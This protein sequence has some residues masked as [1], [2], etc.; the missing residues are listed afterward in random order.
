MSAKILNFYFSLT[1]FACNSQFDVNLPCCNSITVH[2]IVTRDDVIKWRLFHV[3]GPLCGEFTGHRWIPLT[4]ASDA[5]LWCFLW[6][7]PWIN[8]WVNN[9]EDGD[10]RRHRAHH[11]V[12]IIKLATYATAAELSC[13]VE[14]FVPITRLESKWQ[15][16]LHRIRIAIEKLLVKCAPGQ[17]NN[18]WPKK[19]TLIYQ[20]TRKVSGVNRNKLNCIAGIL[21]K[22]INDAVFLNSGSYWYFVK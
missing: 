1:I 20:D 2:Q 10:L 18:Y 5:E 3:T 21:D 16:H 13:H 12:I 6:S 9:C 22:L 4:K 15:S 14:N 8:G 11:D 19:W 17:L 7:A